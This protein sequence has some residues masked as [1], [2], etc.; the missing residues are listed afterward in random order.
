MTSSLDYSLTALPLNGLSK[1]AISTFR[2]L[3]ADLPPWGRHPAGQLR[4]GLDRVRRRGHDDRGAGAGRG[5][6]RTRCH[7]DGN[8]PA[9]RLCAGASLKMFQRCWSAILSG[10][11]RVRATFNPI[12]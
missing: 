5:V 10:C 8:A 11:T 12:E 4:A 2:T 7:E 6:W 1:M 3:P 9:E